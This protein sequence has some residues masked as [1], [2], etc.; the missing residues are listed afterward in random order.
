MRD[1]VNKESF[2]GFSFNGIHT[3]QFGLYSVTNSG[4]YSRDLLPSFEDI[5]VQVEGQNGSYYFGTKDKE[6][7]FQF[8]LAFWD[9]SEKEYYEMV[10][11]LRGGDIPRP[12]IMDE[13]PYVQ[14]Y[15][16]LNKEPQIKYVPFDD[17]VTGRIY[18]GE[19]DLQFKAY[20]PYGYSV[21]KF[22]NE[23]SDDDILSSDEWMEESGLLRTN[24]YN[25]TSIK[26]DVPHLQDN[27]IE[28][29]LINNGDMP[30]DFIL[31]T[32]IVAECDVKTEIYL[33]NT[34]MMTLDTSAWG[35]LSGILT[36][37]SKK[38][39]IFKDGEIANNLLESGDFFQ[40]P[41]GEHLISFNSDISPFMVIYGNLLSDIYDLQMA[42]LDLLIAADF[43]ED[44]RITEDYELALMIENVNKTIAGGADPRCDLSGDGVSI[45]FTDQSLLIDA[46]AYV[47]K[48]NGYI[49]PLLAIGDLNNDGKVDILDYNLVLA[50]YWKNVEDA[51]TPAADLDGNGVIELLDITEIMKLK[52]RAL[53]AGFDGYYQ[54]YPGVG[55]TITYSYKYY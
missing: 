6:R 54:D 5:S 27:I 13:R 11:W 34:L 45:N 22:L 21:H 15:V 12:L 40:I 4:R 2:L 41:L 46:L 14:Y 36:I 30:T 35:V 7:T 31:N 28:I 44:G 1:I 51:I 29:R 53:A 49:L 17:N 16:K 26:Y 37:D 18:K 38:K 48:S 50:D 25:N 32:T 33:N 42:H 9:L 24:V 10:N 52:N 20:D 23:Y 39:A 47:R 55:L 19:I 3:S 8:N 43:N